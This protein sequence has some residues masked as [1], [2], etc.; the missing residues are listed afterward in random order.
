MKIWEVELKEK[1]TP[2]KNHIAAS[3]V[4]TMQV[5]ADDYDLAA[6]NAM[7]QSEW[8]KTIATSVKLIAETTNKE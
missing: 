7:E 5:A 2:A 8:N 4:D 1:N 6:R 3:I